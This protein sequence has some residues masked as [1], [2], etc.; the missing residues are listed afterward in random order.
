M[1]AKKTLDKL[2]GEADRKTFSIYVSETIFEE[3]KAVC[4]P[5][6]PSK[7]LEELMKEFVEDHASKVKKPTK[8]N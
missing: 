7:V 5:I 6:A 2:R 8:K 3:F 1:D 4:G